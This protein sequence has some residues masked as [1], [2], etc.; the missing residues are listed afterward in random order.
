MVLHAVGRLEV[1]DIFHTAGG[2]I[3]EEGDM[4][5]A[6]EQAFRQMGTD[7]TGAAGNQI[8]QR[9][10]L[11]RLGVVVVIA[12]NSLGDHGVSIVVGHIFGFLG[13]IAIRVRIVAIRIVVVRSAGI[14][15]IQDDAENVALD[16][17]EEIAST[18]EG[19]FGGLAAAHDEE[20]AIGLHGQNDGIGV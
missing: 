17:E 19:L 8:T 6:V 18:G 1:A 7:E 9:A 14:H 10:S 11:E 4:I 12:G 20:N 5:A 16:A 15:R 2:E 3:V 13:T